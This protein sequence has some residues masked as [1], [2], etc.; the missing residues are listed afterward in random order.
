MNSPG[1]YN[2]H[3]VEEK[4]GTLSA[5][6]ALL[7]VL[8]GVMLTAS[9][10]T[11]GMNWMAWFAL[12]PL[13]TSI[14]NETPYCAFRSG[15]LAGTVHY[16]TLIYWIVVAM[17]HYGN[18]NVFLSATLLFL[19]SLYLAL[20][21]A[22]FST[23]TIHFDKS[24]LFLLYMGSFWVGLEYIR[25]HLL[26][27]FPWCLL[28]YSQFR[29]LHLIQIADLS[30]VY[31]LTFLIVVVNCLIYRLLSKRNWRGIFSV[32][33]E[34][35]ITALIISV[36]FAYGHFRL[37]QEPTGSESR[38]SVRCAIVQGNIDQSVKWDPAHQANTMLTYQRL[39]RAACDSKPE[40]IVWPE[41]SVPFFF[42]DNEEQSSLLYA[43]ARESGALIVFGSPAYKDIDGVRRYHNRSYALTPLGHPLQYYDKVHLLPFGEYVPLKKL[44]FFVSR[45][46]PATGD[47]EAGKKIVPLSQDKLCMGILICYEA[48]FPELARTHSREGAN[49]LINITNDAWFGITSAPYQH[50]CMSSFR[51]VENRMPMIRAANTGISAFIGTKGNIIEESTIFT[52]DVLKATL[53]ISKSTLTF[54]ARFGDIFALSALVISLVGTVSCLF[55][56]WKKGR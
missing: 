53:D 14:K 34:F 55:T 36:V 16:L 48:I 2:L 5:R 23:L 51:A 35:L 10:P 47:F 20:Y 6:K 37:T 46:V 11:G 30:G 9:F 39:T 27:G 4:H 49:I 13:L 44:L 45:L 18:L 31:G 19:L 8:S 40:L 54:Y 1:Y 52:E 22:L 12:V 43:L 28:G 32:K 38:S 50:L 7:A 29:N 15:L 41:T 17:G 56:K 26:T 33:W 25:A 42:Q 24:R 21:I 3:L